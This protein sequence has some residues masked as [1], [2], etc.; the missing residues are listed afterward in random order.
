MTFLKSLFGGK[1]PSP[2]SFYDFSATS[3]DGEEISMSH[4]R[5]DVVVVVNVATN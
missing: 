2:K 1:S 3:I 4:Y 5:G